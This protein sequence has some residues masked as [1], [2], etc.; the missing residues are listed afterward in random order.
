[1][2]AP[3]RARGWRRRPRLVCA[4]FLASFQVFVPVTGWTGPPRL[5]PRSCWFRHRSRLWRCRAP[6]VNQV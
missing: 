2:V 1:M 6:R 5:L 3:L 4:L